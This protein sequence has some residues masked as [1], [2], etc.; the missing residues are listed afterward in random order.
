[1]GLYGNRILWLK[2]YLLMRRI[3]MRKPLA[4]VLILI[5][6]L[7]L[8]SC[9][10]STDKPEPTGLTSEKPT[11]NNNN[12]SPINESPENLMSDTADKLGITHQNYPRIDGSTSTLSIVRA[13]N[14]AMYQSDENENFPETASKTVP[15]YKLLIDG[16]VDM[17]IMLMP[18]QTFWLK[19]MTQV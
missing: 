10:K 7:S 19:Q 16:E 11:V 6:T 5:M 15:S 14:E 13:I 17:I 18:L 8:V 12:P 9:A 3:T 1:M 4:F 2:N